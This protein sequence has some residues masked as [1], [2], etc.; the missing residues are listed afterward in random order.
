RGGPHAKSEA[1]AARP[2]SSRRDFVCLAFELVRKSIEGRGSTRASCYCLSEQP[3]C[4]PGVAGQKRSVQVRSNRPLQ[5]AAL[6][7]A[8]T[9]VPE[10]G[11]DAAER[12]G[13]VIEDRPTGVILEPRERPRLTLLK[14]ALEQDVADHP[15][16]ARHRVQRK[17]PR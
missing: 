8:L 5:P 13:S 16:L 7:P 15:P 6:E 2:R 11:D 17:H 12:L 3:V 14:L 4:E 9:V 10:S 1:A